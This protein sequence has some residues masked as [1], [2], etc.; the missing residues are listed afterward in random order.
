[1]CWYIFI[2]KNLHWVGLKAVLTDLNNMKS[3]VDKLD[4]DR[5]KSASVYIK[6]PS[7]FV[8]SEF[9]KTMDNTLILKNYTA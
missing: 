6:R 3:D 1:M 4:T 8:K 5:T 2:S 9:A 7:G